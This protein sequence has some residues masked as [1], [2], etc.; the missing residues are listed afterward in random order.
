MAAQSTYT[1]IT[2]VS[3]F[4]GSSSQVIMNSIPQT[5]TDLAIVFN[6][7]T[8][9]SGVYD[10]SISMIANGNYSS[11]YSYTELKGNGSS[12]TSTRLTSINY[13]V[14]S[15]YGA[16]SALSSSSIYAS[17]VFHLLNYSNSTTYKSV[18]MRSS[19]D[20]NGQGGTNLSVGLIQ[21]TSPISSL[22]IQSNGN[23]VSGSTITLYGITAA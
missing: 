22:L 3:G 9:Y 19:G 16:N 20:S 6:L 2:T 14:T 4:S 5:Y 8:T 12:A 23:F 13:G 1:P 18:L 15:V 7:R 11:I 21:T 10:T 17:S